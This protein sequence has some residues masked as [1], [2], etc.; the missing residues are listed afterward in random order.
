MIN[1][2]LP[3]TAIASVNWAKQIKLYYQQYDGQIAESWTN[4]TGTIYYHTEDPLPTPTKPK[5]FTPLAGIT[6][7]GGNDVSY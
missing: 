1:D 4:Y 3:H 7:N 5:L 6:F 2:I